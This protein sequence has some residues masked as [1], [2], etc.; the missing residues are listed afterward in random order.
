MIDES[1][2]QALVSRE[3]VDP[4]GRSVGYVENRLQRPSDRE[5]RMARGH[6]GDMA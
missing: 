1:E 6:D 2:F 4:N 5:A 3:V